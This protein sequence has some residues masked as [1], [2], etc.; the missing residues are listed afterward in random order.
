MTMSTNES[1]SNL[2]L[3][4]VSLGV[5]SILV[6]YQFGWP[7]L[8]MTICALVAAFCSMLYVSE[9]PRD[10]TPKAQAIFAVVML[11]AATGLAI[12]GWVRGL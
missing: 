1:K 11:S 6:H 5:V 2:S 8:V 9:A 7:V 12:G 10:Q 4:A 3:F